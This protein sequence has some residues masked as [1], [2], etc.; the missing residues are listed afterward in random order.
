MQIYKLNQHS[1][2]HLDRL[3]KD[4]DAP[5][6][7]FFKPT[8]KVAYLNNRKSG[9]EHK[10]HVFE[11]AASQCRCRTR[12]VNRFLHTRDAKS[13]SNLRRHAQICWGT[14]TVAAADNTPNVQTARAALGARKEVDGSIT[15]SFERVGKGK[16][17]YSHKQHTKAEARYAP[18]SSSSLLHLLIKYLAVPSS[19]DGLQRIN[20]PFKL[21]TTVLSDLL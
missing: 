9:E 3:S 11:C 2:V 4:W 20:D 17:T 21:S 12:F 10:A 8:V 15:A 7:V 16:V 5:I 18:C 1:Y 13:T 14:D 19:C 6:Y